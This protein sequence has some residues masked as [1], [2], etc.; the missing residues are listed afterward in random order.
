MFEAVTK[1]NR[2]SE[3]FEK[4]LKKDFVFIIIKIL[5]ADGVNVPHI[6]ITVTC[7]Q[8]AKM[9]KQKWQKSGPR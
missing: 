3:K 1:K 9:M 8:F 7:S 4:I 6:R 2:K 5:E